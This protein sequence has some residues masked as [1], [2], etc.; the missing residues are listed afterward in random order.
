MKIR[1]AQAFVICCAF[2]SYSQSFDYPFDLKSYRHPTFFQQGLGFSPSARVI[3]GSE[4]AKE[5]GNYDSH[6]S[7]S[8]DYFF[9][10]HRK[11]WQLSGEYRLYGSGRKDFSLDSS[12][13]YDSEEVRKSSS[14]VS[15]MLENSGCYYVSGPVYIGGRIR[16]SNSFDRSYQKRIIIG[17]SDYYSDTYEERG[18]KW[19][20]TNVYADV[21]IRVGGIS[22]VTYPAVLM[23]MLDRIQI[24]GKKDLIISAE[25]IQKLASEIEILKR[26]RFLL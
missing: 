17:N 23:N 5:W 14:Q 22:D 26:S 18:S 12:Y 10:I 13:S 1:L 9:K 16:L 11:I 20:S 2:L 21:K 3:G 25:Q 6:G 8:A 24:V 4:I 15:M 7:L 19:F